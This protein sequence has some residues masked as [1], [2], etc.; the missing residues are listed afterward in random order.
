[1]K[2]H[3]EALKLLVDDYIKDSLSHLGAGD[4]YNSFDCLN[5]AYCRC[6]KYLV[7]AEANKSKH[8]DLMTRTIVFIKLFRQELSTLIAKLSN[9]END[10]YLISNEEAFFL[11]SSLYSGYLS[12]D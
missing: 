1:M 12:T 2:M 4:R 8:S 3:T 10:V 9:K 7:G 11:V 5:T 6:S